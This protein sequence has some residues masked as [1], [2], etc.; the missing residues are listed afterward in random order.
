M[1]R[2]LP[3]PPKLLY[4][5]VPRHRPPAHTIFL[6]FCRWSKPWAQ[7][8]INSYGHAYA[9][10][11]GMDHAWFLYVFRTTWGVLHLALK[12]GQV[13]KHQLVEKF[14]FSNHPIITRL[15]LNMLLDHKDFWTSSCDHLLVWF[16]IFR[17]L[18]MDKSGRTR[19]GTKRFFFQNHPVLTRLT[20]KNVFESYRFWT[21]NANVPYTPTLPCWSMLLYDLCTTS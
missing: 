19:W 1:D 16:S 10:A 4:D 18:K 20:L 15:T 13:K 5:L 11:R 2:S 8:A 9:A 17:P 21:R 6:Y 3:G 7:L 12:S 14:F